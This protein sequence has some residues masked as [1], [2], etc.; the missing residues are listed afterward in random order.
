M[1]FAHSAKPSERRPFLAL[2][3]TRRRDKLSRVSAC[4]WAAGAGPAADQMT[5]LGQSCIAVSDASSG[6]ITPRRHELPRRG[7]LEPVV[8][9]Y[10]RGDRPVLRRSVGRESSKGTLRAQ[11]RSSHAQRSGATGGQGAT[12]SNRAGARPRSRSSSVEAPFSTSLFANVGERVAPSRPRGGHAVRTLVLGA[13][14]RSV[15]CRAGRTPGVK[16]VARARPK[17]PTGRGLALGRGPAGPLRLRRPLL[18][19]RPCRHGSHAGEA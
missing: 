9:R 15:R 3:A 13:I 12:A 1:Q 7:R 5:V 17:R 18:P 14:R 4:L 10:R 16:P 2:P 8:D 6:H 11:V 19:A